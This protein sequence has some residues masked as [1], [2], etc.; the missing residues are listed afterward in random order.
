MGI[1]ADPILVVD[2]DEAILRTVEATLADEGYTVLAASDGAA[3]LDLVRQRS[4]S[5]ILLDMKMPVMDGWGFAR[6]YRAQPRPHAPIVV[7]TAAVNAGQRA[8]EIGARGY[9][10]KPFNLDDLLAMVSQCLSHDRGE[11]E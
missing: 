9:L 1:A 11:H 4:P 3:A 5:L 6:A 7:L 8:A 2:D 10:A